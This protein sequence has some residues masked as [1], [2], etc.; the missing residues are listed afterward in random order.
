MHAIDAEASRE[1]VKESLT[2][3][4][5]DVKIAAIQCLGDSPEYLSYMIEQSKAK[6]KDLRGAA[7]HALC[8]LPD[9]EALEVFC[10][11]S[12]SDGASVQDQLSNCSSGCDLAA[13]QCEID[14]ALAAIYDE[15]ED[16]EQTKGGRSTG[17]GGSA[18]RLAKW[19]VERQD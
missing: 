17:L 3:G 13:D 6:A 19:L 16:G 4:S 1:F 2:T 15:S 5:A 9:P 12:N 11:G 14:Q 7:Y 10:I 8:K 18:P